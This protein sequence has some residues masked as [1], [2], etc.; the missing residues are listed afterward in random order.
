VANKHTGAKPGGKVDKRTHPS[1]KKLQLQLDRRAKWM[2]KEWERSPTYM[3]R[4]AIAA[5]RERFDIGETSAETAYA[6]AREM[7][8]DGCEKLDMSRLQREYW[9]CYEMAISQGKPRDG[10]RIMSLMGVATG[11][12]VAAKHQVTVTGSITVAQTAHVAVLHLTPIQRKHREAELLAKAGVDLSTPDELIDS[13]L[14]GVIDAIS[15]EVIAA[16][17]PPEDDDEPLDATEAQP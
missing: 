13:M 15:T 4:D 3:Y 12:A 2:I 5:L 8:A 9:R 14:V 1:T 6:R 7:F 11:V 16:G 17:V 10:A